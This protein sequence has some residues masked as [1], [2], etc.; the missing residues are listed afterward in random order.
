MTAPVAPGQEQD[1]S[2]SDELEEPAPSV[3]QRSPLNHG[4]H[5]HPYLFFPFAVRF[6]VFLYSLG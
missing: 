6:V 1:D 4:E 2:A 5:L 3:S